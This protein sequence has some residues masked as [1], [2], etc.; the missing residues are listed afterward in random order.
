MIR[1]ENGNI[2]LKLVEEEE[3]TYG[4]IVVPDLGKEKAKLYEVIATS[5]TY[6][7]HTDKR[8]FSVLEKGEKVFIPAF[9]GT[10]VM[11][12]N[13]EYILIKETEI[14]AVYE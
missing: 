3:Q 6:N 13:D 1:P 14:L 2:L 7:F 4:N 10:K 8:V 9:G 5:E 12:G 11:D